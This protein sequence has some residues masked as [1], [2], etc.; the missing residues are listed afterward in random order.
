MK[1]Y[2]HRLDSKTWL[3]IFAFIQ[4]TLKSKDIWQNGQSI[5]FLSVVNE[6]RHW[7]PMM[8]PQC[9]QGLHFHNNLAAIVSHSHASQFLSVHMGQIIKSL[10]SACLSVCPLSYGCNSHLILTKLCTIVWNP[11]SKIEFVAGQNQTTPFPI[12]PQIFHLRT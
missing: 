1:L 6:A 8:I 4:K 12:F 9:S 7:Q 5:S 2:S 10:A 3:I 11:K